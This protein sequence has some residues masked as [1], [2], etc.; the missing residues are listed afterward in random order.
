MWMII[1]LFALIVAG[2]TVP[3][4]GFSYVGFKSESPLPP[5]VL[6]CLG[7]GWKTLND[8]YA[9]GNGP[10]RVI[11]SVNGLVGGRKEFQISGLVAGLAPSDVFFSV[12]LN[13]GVLRVESPSYQAELE[14]DARTY[15]EILL[16]RISEVLA[17]T[18]VQ[19]RN[20][21]TNIRDE[22]RFKDSRNSD[23]SRPAGCV[24]PGDEFSDY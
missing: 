21:E 20:L 11:E 23:G 10:R 4:S 1:Q 8:W 19:F 9:D 6:K 2:G 13:G 16:G 3:T 24:K 17:P 15:A 5:E 18:E 14:K 12:R 7:P 22:L